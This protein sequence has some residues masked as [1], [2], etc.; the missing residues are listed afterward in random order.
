MKPV[1][2][3]ITVL[4]TACAAYS[5]ISTAQTVVDGSDGKPRLATIARASPTRIAVDGGRVMQVVYDESELKV[6]ED[7]ING[8]VFV[9]PT[10]PDRAAPISLFVLT[11]QATHALVL[12][13]KDVPVAT[14]L[15]RESGR[16][17][18]DARVVSKVAIEKAGALDLGVKRLV[19]VMARGEANPEFK[20]TELR[21]PRA[22]WNEVSLVLLRRFEGRQL[23]G[24]HYQ[25][26]NVSG[27]LMRL[28]EQELYQPGVVAVSIELHQLAPGSATNI[29]VVRMAN[30]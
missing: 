1:R 25:L 24:E 7:K 15:I 26:R 11:E 19:A 23:I 16:A 13:P 12:E 9:V 27:A 18:A 29:F 28:A 21:E 10:S 17:S 14:V 20:M 5:S 6:S 4:V 30:G 8:Q 3:F 2:R 22:L